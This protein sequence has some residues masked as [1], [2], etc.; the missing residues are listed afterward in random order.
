MAP[1]RRTPRS[2]PLISR[3]RATLLDPRV[4]LGLLLVA[5]SVVGVVAIV[6]TADDTIEV[7]SAREPVAPGD[8]L[9]EADLVVRS[10]GPAAVAEQYLSPGDIPGGGV[11]AARSIGVGELVPASAVGDVAGLRQAAIVIDTPTRLPA[12]VIAGS[13]VDLWASRVDEGGAV[14]PPVVI[15]S[16]AA[17]VSLV[18]S[19]SIMGGG[20]TVSG[21]ELLVPKVRIARVVEALARGDVLAVIPTGVPLDR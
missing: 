15:V 14:A 1:A 10:V 4:I 6:T 8:L 3:L 17:V 19:E 20:G 7:Y 9:R 13:T 2:S 12:S 21:V 16:G 5:G 18:E 11:L